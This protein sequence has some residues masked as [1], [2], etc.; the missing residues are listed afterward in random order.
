MPAAPE[1]LSEAKLRAE[2][3]KL[4]VDIAKTNVELRK[5]ERERRLYPVVVGTGV[6]LA[7]VGI[8]RLFQ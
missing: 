8:L 6:L 3:D 1:D 4:K 2:I 5:L 7:F